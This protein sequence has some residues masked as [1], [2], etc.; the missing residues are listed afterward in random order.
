MKMR[1]NWLLIPA[2]AIGMGSCNKKEEAKA[3][4]KA[5]ELTGSASGGLVTESPK[6][7]VP[8]ASADERAAKLGFAKHL[9]KD[10]EAAI[11]FYN[12]SKIADR[13]QT[14]KLWNLVQ[15]QMGGGAGLMGPGDG[16]EM[17]NEDLDAPEGEQADDDTEALAGDDAEPAGM[18]ELFGS[19]ITLAMGKTTGEQMGH[20]A[21]LNRRS[22]YFQ[23]RGLA[24]AF[25][26][27]V[28]S[29]DFSNMEESLSQGY[30]AD[31]IKDLLKDPES[32]TAM[33]EKMKMPP[34]YLAFRTTEANRAGAAQQ[35]A[36]ML[37]N[38]NMLG[39]MV[40]PV[41]LESAGFKFQGTKLLGAKI[42]ETMAAER[43]SMEEELDAA[44]VDQL[45]AA[46]AKKDLIVASGTVGDYVVVF[47]GGAAED[48]QLAADAGQS[49]AGGDAL[50][51]SDGYLA[52]DIVSV[53]YGQKEAMDK[54]IAA[55]G[56][57]SDITN[58]LSDGLAGEDGLGETRDL[59]ALF[60]IVGEREAALRKLGGNDASGMVAFFEDGLKIE[61]HGGYDY[62]MV[63]WKSA[64]KLAHLG[65]SDDVLVF[66]NMTA[67]ATYD[68]KATEYLE[69]LMETAYAVT[70]KVSQSPSSAP[71]MAQFQ[72]AAKLFDTQFR[73]DML[74]LWDA[75]SNDFGGSLGK[76]SAIVV[77]LKGGAP[78]VPGIPQVIVDKGRVPRIT[79][80]APVTDR[81]K[82]SGS[83]DKMNTTVT[84]TLKKIS[85]MTGQEIPMQKPI[86]SEK[87]GAVTWFFP[88]PFFT[89]DF[90]PSVTVSDKWFAAS[91]SKNQALDLIN[92]ADTGGQTREGFWFSINFKALE[93]Y[94]KETYQLIDENSAELMGGSISADQKKLVQD[95]IGLLG[96]LDKLTVHSRREAGKLRSSIHFKTR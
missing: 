94:A 83:W 28:K 23:M 14:S 89:D 67:D 85:E 22:T 2:V 76:E 11:A 38:A 86:S 44:T 18:A 34:V 13:V 71:E 24:K 72:E 59:E 61:S 5:G 64:N 20:L 40:E 29:G 37:A 6:V 41:T 60:R 45:L 47:M 42:S 55:A 74:S 12:G 77:D 70:M 7:E 73:P 27:A 43:E 54:L 1:A 50:A 10:T 63:D 58:G 93:T 3:P 92:L 84:G 62:G 26:A 80:V 25:A 8:K 19:E 69:A 21:T 65:A 39:P 32:G 46:L 52:K 68:E 90:L 95:S 49:L 16:P 81:V 87:N 31:M 33:L 75:F 17:D 53:V 82:L 4:E 9:P 57:L 35:V 15:E 79:L 36:S 66:A 51:F 78:A 88:L 96:D 30:S 48:L 91:S 56:G